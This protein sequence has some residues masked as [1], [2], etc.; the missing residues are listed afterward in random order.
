MKANI[1]KSVIIIV[2][3]QNDFLNLVD[4]SQGESNPKM[5]Q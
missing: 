3:M 1:G 4:I 2:D 5:I